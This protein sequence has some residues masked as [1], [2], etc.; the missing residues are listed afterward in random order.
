MTAARSAPLAAALEVDPFTSLAVHFGMLLGVA[1]FQ[2]LAAN[3]RGK[4]ALHQAWQH[5][6][7]IDWGYPVHAEKGNAELVVG[8]GLA[9]DGLG[10]HVH[11]DVEQCL[12]VRVWLDQQM[13][14]GKVEPRV[15][16][17][18]RTFDAQLVLRHEA[19]LS[20]PVPTVGSTC[21]QGTEKPEYSRVRELA[22][23]DL[24]P[25]TTRPCPPDD[26]FA[27]LRALVRDGTLPAGT[28]RGENRLA[29]FRR[30]AAQA[31]AALGPPG[32]LPP[33]RA[34]SSTLL[35]EDEPGEIVLADLPGLTVVAE[36]G[37][38]RLEAPTIDLSV[39]PVHVPVPVI[40][41]LIA[42]LLDGTF[43]ASCATDAGGPR[44]VEPIQRRDSRVVIMFDR[45]VVAGTVGPAL[46]VR[47]FDASAAEPAWGDP[48]T[49]APTFDDPQTLRFDLP[50]APTADVSYRLVLRGTGPTP[51]VGLV[52]DRPLPLAGWV[53]GPPGSTADGHDVTRLFRPSGS[54]S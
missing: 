14:A 27:A 8:P 41:E 11:S 43:D 2:I 15:E 38:W 12:D 46:E 54:A 23:L 4:L 32:V 51:L 34:G 31:V 35:P 20:R 7:G 30:I 3:P 36:T 48:I 40:A 26:P 52:D 47:A 49:V 25:Y 22:R 24:R 50:A 17:P 39:R 5:G 42:E 6:K 18:R 10:R 44:V 16:G 37:T 21:G 19:C 13:Q 53:G 29:D 33:H 9:T 45:P 28:A 1:D